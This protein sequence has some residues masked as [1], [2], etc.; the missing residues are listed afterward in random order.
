SSFSF[1]ITSGHIYSG[2]VKLPCEALLKSRSSFRDGL[3]ESVSHL[4]ILTDSIILILVLSSL[5]ELSTDLLILYRF[6]IC[7]GI[8]N[9]FLSF[10][11]SELFAIF[12]VVVRPTLAELSALWLSCSW[13]CDALARSGNLSGLATSVVLV[14]RGGSLS[15]VHL[16][17][18]DQLMFSRFILS[19]LKLDTQSAGGKLRD[20]NTEESWVLLEDL[21][22]YDNEIWN[23]P[24]D[25]SSQ[26]VKA[27]SFCPGFPSTPD[28]HLMRTPKSSPTLMKFNFLSK[29]PVQLNKDLFSCKILQ[30]S[31]DTQNCKENHEQFLLITHLHVTTS[32]VLGMNSNLHNPQNGSFSTYSSSYQTKLEKALS[33]F[34]YCQE[35]RLQLGQQQDDMINKINTLWRAVSEKLNDTPT[36]DTTGNSMAHVNAAS[37]NYVKKE[38]L[39]KQSESKPIAIY[40]PQKF[41][42]QASFEE[43]NKNPHPQNAIQ[44][45]QFGH[46]SSKESEA[47]EEGGLKS[48]RKSSNP[49][50]ISNC[51]GRVKG[52]KVFVGNFTYECDFV[53]LEDTTSVIDHYL[54][55]MVLGKPFVKETG[56]VYD[57]DEGMVKSEEK[58]LGS[59]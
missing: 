41:L 3:R 53:M 5:A 42:S 45:H 4:P 16:N 40:S 28:R 10:R 46:H 17:Q 30:W 51:V 59:S 36:L 27:I 47:K 6:A 39:P 38:T 18:Q 22:L 44:F 26:L 2:K 8:V 7:S 14:Q 43:Q 12:G 54:G 24:R 23:D 13:I 33:D 19:L 56:L 1:S 34:D 21:A 25:L 49:E 55:G 29:Q 50:K 48:R 31:H 58:K 32:W 37:V 57:K 11:H 35:R 9:S 52:L 20:R 15:A